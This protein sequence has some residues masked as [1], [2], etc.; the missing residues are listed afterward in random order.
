[1]KKEQSWER[2]NFHDTQHREI[3]SSETAPVSPSHGFHG[4]HATGQA[5]D[6][7]SP[8]LCSIIGQ[9]VRQHMCQ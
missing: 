2:L 5:I 8:D 7:A 9:L 1:M 4:Y 6:A 3:T